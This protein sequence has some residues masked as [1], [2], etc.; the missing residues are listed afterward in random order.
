MTGSEYDELKEQEED[1]PPKV[2]ADDTATE[3]HNA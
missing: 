1:Q 3:T 2:G